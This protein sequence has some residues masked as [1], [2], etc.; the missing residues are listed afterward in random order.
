MGGG[1]GMSPATLKSSFIITSKNSSTIDQLHQ[2]ILIGN[3]MDANYTEKLNC[4]TAVRKSSHKNLHGMDTTV[5]KSMRGLSNDHVGG[6]SMMFSG[7]KT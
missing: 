4:G 7:D 5:R 6:I 1:E 2:E 3:Q